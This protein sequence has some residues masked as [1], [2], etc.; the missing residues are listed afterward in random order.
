MTAGGPFFFFISHFLLYFSLTLFLKTCSYLITLL[1]MLNASSL[2]RKTHS[3]QFDNY[4]SSLKKSFL[5][6]NCIFSLSKN[7]LAVS[8]LIFQKYQFDYRLPSHP[9]KCGTFFG[10][11]WNPL[12]QSFHKIFSKMNWSRS[13]R[14]PTP[15]TADQ[16]NLLWIW[17]LRFVFIFIF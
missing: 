14:P 12:D 2:K 1:Y 4:T 10:C 16:A 3:H 7:M 13:L 15:H 6:N 5:F 17:H 11:S 9:N 8:F